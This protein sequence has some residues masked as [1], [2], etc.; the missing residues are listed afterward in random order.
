M[1]RLR[2]QEGTVVTSGAECIALVMA[3]GKGTRMASDL[4]KV[5]HEI[6]GEPLLG[7]V[8]ARLAELGTRGL[9][10]RT[11]V[12]TGHGA[13]QVG[14]YLGR[15]WPAAGILLQEPQLGTGHA[16][17]QARGALQGHLGSV[18]ILNGDV[19]LLETETL[20]SM[21]REHQASG[22]DLTLM[23]TEMP[24]PTG[25]GR[26]VR[27]ASGEVARIVEHRDASAE[28]RDVREVN[29]GVY[30]ASWPALSE[31]LDGLGTANDQGEYYLTDAVAALVSDGSKVSA[32]RLSDWTQTVGINNRAELVAAGALWRQRR[33]AYWLERQVTIEDPATT[34]L[35]PEVC[36]GPDT[37][38][39]PFTQ[40][41]GRTSTGRGVRVGSHTRLQDV[42]LG[43]GVTVRTSDLADAVI[44]AGSQ[45]GPYARMRDVV[46]VG[47]GARIGNFVELKKVDFGEG[48]KAAHLSY[49]GDATVGAAANIGCGTVTCN[50]DGERKHPTVIGAGAFIGTNNTLVAPLRVGD[51][52]YTA[53]GSTLTR[54]VPEGALALG[55]A[56]QV[57]KEGW[58]ARRHA[59]SRPTTRTP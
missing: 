8:L 53:A 46:R 30:L 34:H 51:G 14:E 20:A 16:V 36:L 55:R 54:D 25:F 48:A 33:A 29:V 39:E 49:L 1:V 43:D 5:L 27:K 19:P 11:F 32:F 6:A 35:G 22:A 12:I 41:Y 24:D 58:V 57:V 17:M 26:I 47:E 40:L 42:Q 38:I 23:T 15:R 37:V 4:P 13:E 3:A 10:D 50:Y 18:L 7:F 44:G 21:L 2:R 28:E 45:V 59:L 31:A 9:V 52:A 56:Q